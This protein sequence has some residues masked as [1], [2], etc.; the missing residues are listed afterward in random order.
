M[1][2][3]PGSRTATSSPGACLSPRTPGLPTCGLA[4]ACPSHCWLPLRRELPQTVCAT[5]RPQ[6]L[7]RRPQGGPGEGRQFRSQG[8][9]TRRAA[10]LSGTTRRLAIKAERVRVLVSAGPELPS[11]RRPSLGSSPT[12]PARKLSTPN[13]A[14]PDCS[15]GTPFQHPPFPSPLGLRAGTGGSAQVAC[16]LKSVGSLHDPPPVG[17]QSWTKGGGGACP[18][19]RI[20]DP[21]PPTHSP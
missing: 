14:L 12:L 19:S 18:E 16:T 7:G 6:D 4:P 9:P 13:W 3:L 20:Q 1:Q 21:A 5:Q 15:E 8:V 10:L 2:D 17:L 11:H